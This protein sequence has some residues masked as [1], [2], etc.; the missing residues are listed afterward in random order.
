[1][2]L[3]I[4]SERRRIT[5][6]TNGTN[7]A[8]KTV[9]GRAVSMAIFVIASKSVLKCYKRLVHSSGSRAVDKHIFQSK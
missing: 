7:Q 3:L 6:K 5:H 4:I 1:M 9:Q 8:K 2:I